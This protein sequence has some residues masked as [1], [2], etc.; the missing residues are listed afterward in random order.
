MASNED[1]AALEMLAERGYNLFLYEEMLLLRDKLRECSGVSILD[2]GVNAIE[3]KDEYCF[4]R[5][6]DQKG[7]YM[8]QLRQDKKYGRIE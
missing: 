5:F 7:L 6:V 3:D 2:W 4:I 8:L 1:N